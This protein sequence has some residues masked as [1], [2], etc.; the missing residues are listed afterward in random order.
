M[1]KSLLK[2]VNKNDEEYAV[3]YREELLFKNSKNTPFLCLKMEK[4]GA[5]K[6]LPFNEF[7]ITKEDIN[8]MQLRFFAPAVV[9]KLELICDENNVYFNFCKVGKPDNRLYIRLQKKNTRTVGLGL[10]GKKDLEGT[11]LS[12]LERIKEKK[13]DKNFVNIDNTLNFYVVN[14]YYFSNNNIN[15][16]EVLIKNEVTLSSCQEKVE[17]KLEFNKRFNFLPQ[18]KY[19]I[20]KTKLS[21]V[22][23]EIDLYDGFIVDYENE[24]RTRYTI[25]KIRKEGK[26]I[27]IKFSPIIKENDEDIERYNLNTLVKIEGGYL[28][29]ISDEKNLRQYC[30]R[31]RDIFNLNPD[32]IYVDEKSIKIDKEIELK[33]ILFY[34]NLHALINEIKEEYPTKYIIFNKLN[35]SEKEK[36][37]IE[38]EEEKKQDSIIYFYKRNLKIQKEIYVVNYN[39]IKKKENIYINSLLF[40]GYKSYFYE[41]GEEDIENLT[42]QGKTQII[43][44]R[45]I[46]SKN[47]CFLKKKVK[48]KH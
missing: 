42:Q 30:R 28:L 32:G 21:D 39:E 15:D 5:R 16:W 2:I 27:F 37:V 12:V 45:E 36:K 44:D 40:S 20:L 9:V 19:I 25:S 13:K 31:I 7:E 29:N 33:N 46:L 22:E 38:K 14:G 43:I 17:F 18:N 6:L 4:E 26:S 41:C 11:R 35:S 48:S 1:E 34:E 23:K 47:K 24:I 3:F 10:N 8:Y